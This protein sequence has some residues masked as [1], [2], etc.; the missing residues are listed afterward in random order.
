MKRGLPLSILA[1]VLVAALAAGSCGSSKKQ[2][3]GQPSSSTPTQPAVSETAS[4]TSAP[5]RSIGSATPSATVEEDIDTIIKDY[6]LSKSSPSIKDVRIDKKHYYTDSS[7]TIWL[8][9]NV[10]PIPEGVTDPAYG[11]MKKVPGGSW[12]GVAGPGTSPV[13]CDLPADVQ[14]GLGL[15]YCSYPPIVTPT[16][17]KTAS[18]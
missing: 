17:S 15:H 6:V 13:H 14:T 18:N 1:L 16:A 5:T 11:I 4:P 10:S 3:Q 8:G 7:G 12:E 2:G 9:F